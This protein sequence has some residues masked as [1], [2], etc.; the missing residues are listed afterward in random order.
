M[1]FS[2]ARKKYLLENYFGT[3]NDKNIPKN[4]YVFGCRDC[5]TS[6]E[7]LFFVSQYVTEIENLILGGTLISKQGL[8]YL[9]KIQKVT[10]LDLKEIPINDQD[11]DCILHLKNVEYL[12]IKHTGITING[13][14]EILKSFSSLKTIVADIP[15]ADLETLQKQYPNCEF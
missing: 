4:L 11:L 5:N 7:E 15:S 13:I 1:K 6:D 9:K 2:K 3:K 12:Y 14:I 8:Q 10:Y